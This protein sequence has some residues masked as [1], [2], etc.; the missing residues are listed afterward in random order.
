MSQS[1]QNQSPVRHDQSSRAQNFMST[2][3]EA[4]ASRDIRPLCALFASDA[5][6][7]NLTRPFP[8]N[9]ANHSTEPAKVSAAAYWRQ[10]LSAFSSVESHFT[11]VLECGSTIILEWQSTGTLANGTPIEYNGVSLLESEGSEIRKF[12]SYFDSAA[13]LPHAPKSEKHYSDSV[14]TPTISSQ[15]SS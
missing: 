9:I 10:Y 8:H 12:R 15:A 5:E 4:E 1:D 3:R 14:G 13:L 6:L 11:R 2:L 7:E